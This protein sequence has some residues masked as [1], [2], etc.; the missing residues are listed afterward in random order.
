MTLQFIQLIARGYFDYH[1][2]VMTYFVAVWVCNIVAVSAMSIYPIRQTLVY[3][4]Q[5]GALV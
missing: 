1:A 3:F 4:K 5:R 2:L